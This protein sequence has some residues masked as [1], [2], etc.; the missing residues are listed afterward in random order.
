VLVEID[1]VAGHLE[2]ETGTA[3]STTPMTRSTT[4][5]STRSPDASD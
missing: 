5:S 1:E 3:P 2:E 4:A